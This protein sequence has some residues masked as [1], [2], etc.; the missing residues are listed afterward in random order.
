MYHSKPDVSSS[1][2]SHARESKVPT[3]GN[4]RMFISFN[5]RFKMNT[6]GD[7]DDSVPLGR[8]AAPS[9]MSGVTGE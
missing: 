4:Y 8:I 6:S 3:D 5:V 7:V 2:C 1:F 9:M